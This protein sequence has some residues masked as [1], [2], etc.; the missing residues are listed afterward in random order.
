M[1][2]RPASTKEAAELEQVAQ[3]R[4]GRVFVAALIAVLLLAIG[5]AVQILVAAGPATGLLMP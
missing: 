1:R 4:E 3:H 5:S 2:L